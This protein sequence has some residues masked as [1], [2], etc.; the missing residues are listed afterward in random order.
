MQ[1][2]KRGGKVTLHHSVYQAGTQQIRNKAAFH[3]ADGDASWNAQ[4]G[5]NHDSGISGPLGVGSPPL[6][7]IW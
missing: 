7:D 5:D 3:T 4:E 1:T 2:K 6:H